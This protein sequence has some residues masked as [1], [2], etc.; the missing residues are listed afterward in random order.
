MVQNAAL[1]H[2]CELPL[3]LVQTTRVEPGQVD[4]PKALILQSLQLMRRDLTLTIILPSSVMLVHLLGNVR[5]G[6]KVD[7]SGLSGHYDLLT[8]LKKRRRLASSMS[9]K[10]AQPP[11]PQLEA[12]KASAIAL[13]L[14]PRT[15]SAG[16]EWLRL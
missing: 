13:H 12:S 2:L 7:V 4:M 10:P 1:E 14:T 15:S 16:S 8:L 5:E 6:L 3:V 11:L 9:K